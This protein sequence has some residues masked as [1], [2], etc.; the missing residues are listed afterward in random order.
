[1]DKIFRRSVVPSFRRSV[2]PSFRRSVV[3]SFRRS[4]VPNWCVYVCTL[5]LQSESTHA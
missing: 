4:V 2:V 1:M 5:E 3:P